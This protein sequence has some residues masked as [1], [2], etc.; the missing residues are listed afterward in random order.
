[1]SFLETPGDNEGGSLGTYVLTKSF[2]D[3]TED[4]ETWIAGIRSNSKTVVSQLSQKFNSIEITALDPFNLLISDVLQCY[5]P[6]VKPSDRQTLTST[7]IG[8]GFESGSQEAVDKIMNTVFDELAHRNILQVHESSPRNL[9]RAAVK[10]LLYVGC[11]YQ[12]YNT[13]VS[14]SL[15]DFINSLGDK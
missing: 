1:M 13:D 4:Y 9:V 3:P 10:A 15:S 5:N 8:I 11:Y 12:Q 14:N 2:F 7:F 6:H